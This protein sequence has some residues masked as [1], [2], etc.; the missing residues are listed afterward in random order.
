MQ[1]WIKLLSGLLLVQLLLALV[2]NLSSEEH[3]AYQAKDKLL[4]F[5]PQSVDRL[6]IESDGKQVSLQKQDGHWLLPD[7]GHFPADQASVKRLLDSLAGL[8]QGWP[9]A[10]T[11]SAEWR[12]KVADDQFNTRITLLQGEQPLARLYVGT[13]PGFRKVHVRPEGAEAVFSV[14]F[15]SWEAGAKADDWI[16]KEILKLDPGTVEEVELP[17]LTLQR[18]EN[19][20]QVAKLTDQEQ[21][22]PEAVS[23]LIG[24]LTGLRI[25]SVLG[26]QARP[27]Y[28]LDSPDLELKLVRQQ[29][30][31]LDYRFAKPEGENN[32]VLKRSDL[33]YYFKVPE[34]SVKPILET[35]RQK[36]VQSEIKK[37]AE[38]TAPA[39]S[40]QDTTSADPMVQKE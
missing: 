28:R 21:T 35:D 17:D 38:E 31:P 2:V 11:G 36:L 12:F 15:N 14:A 10:T 18:K 24:R 20:L 22:D 6:Q 16:D 30:E 27:E 39:E 4:S 1:K 25:Q 37:P 29:G 33:D 34:F 3:G 40:H 32:Y 8:K 9:V 7:V 19:G 26:T 23:D 5:D 13:S